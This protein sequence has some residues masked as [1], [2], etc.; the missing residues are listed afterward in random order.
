MSFARAFGRILT[1]A[2]TLLLAFASLAQAQSNWAIARRDDANLRKLIETL[3]PYTKT[4]P[5]ADGA[6]A[7]IL[8]K[9][10]FFQMEENG[11]RVCA[12]LVYQVEDPSKLD[13]E[14]SKPY[15]GPGDEYPERSAFILRKDAIQRFDEKK[16]DLIKGD[17]EMSRDQVE[18]RWG[19]LEKGDIVGW[20]VVE[21][22]KGPL[23]GWISAATDRY[24]V[25]YASLRILNDG[26]SDFV[27]GS[28]GIEAANF[29]LKTNGL[30][31]DRTKEWRANVKD[32][33]PIPSLAATGPYPIDTPVFTIALKA[34]H[35]DRPNFYTGW[36]P[37]NG[38][39]TMAGL[40]VAAKDK[41]LEETGG[42][43]ISASALTSGL[44]DEVA[45]EKA[46]C[47]FVRDKIADV[48]EDRYERGTL[49]SVKKVLAS[50]EGTP[51]EKVAVMIA[52]LD[53]VGIK[54]QIA[55]ARPEKWGSL[56]DETDNSFTSFLARVVRCGSKEGRYYVP[57][58]DDCA[59]GT[60]PA[61]WGNAV[62]FYPKSGLSQE[63]EAYKKK[64]GSDAFANAGRLNLLKISLEAEKHGE[65]EGWYHF[66]TYKAK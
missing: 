55:L 15:F 42:V 43:D 62:M 32:L 3:T 30:A 8:Y 1:G 49:R 59:A 12:N 34:R 26:S 14:L 63:L 22:H 24:P 7:I 47:E 38:W 58:Y 25:I 41:M 51:L 35:I 23:F 45:K 17:G 56:K 31:N 33:A 66:E 19:N 50:K 10:H 36:V 6:A 46:I 11:Y 5:G 40:L 37:M 18:I 13:S 21:V 52:M 9:Q 2:V 64:L 48:K 65:K 28:H 61:E 20:S 44:T 16:I 39:V 27:V 57:Q 54:S 29:T 53:A 4:V 60:I